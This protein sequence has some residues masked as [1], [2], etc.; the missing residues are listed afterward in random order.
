VASRFKRERRVADLLLP[1]VSG[2]GSHAG[3]DF[4]TV[5]RMLGASAALEKPFGRDGLLRAVRQALA[6]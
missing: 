5:A 4:L 2:G 3:G 6:G 1:A